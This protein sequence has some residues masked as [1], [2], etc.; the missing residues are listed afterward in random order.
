MSLGAIY[1]PV[2]PDGGEVSLV[3]DIDYYSPATRCW[4]LGY[5][6]QWVAAVLWF[7]IGVFLSWL[8]YHLGGFA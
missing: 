2:P 1:I 7:F 5:K 6:R 8:A 4:L 3:L